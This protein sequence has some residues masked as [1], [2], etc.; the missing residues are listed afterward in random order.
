MTDSTPDIPGALGDETLCPVC[1][2]TDIETISSG[3][4]ALDY[5]CP[6]YDAE[7]DRN[8]G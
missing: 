1:N 2:S 7:F 5:R 4:P 3:N 8:G 6:E